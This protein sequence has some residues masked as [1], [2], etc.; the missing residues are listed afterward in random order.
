MA[1]QDVFIDKKNGIIHCWDDIKGHETFPISIVKYAYRRSP[2]GKY[3]SLYGDK[4]DRVTS[5]NEADPELFESDVPLETKFLL[6]RYP[7]DDEISKNANIVVIDIEVDST[8]GFP[9]VTK[10]DK[11][12]TAIALY[13]QTG[14]KYYSYVLDP[15]GKITSNNTPELETRSFSNE[16]SLLDVFLTT[17]EEIRPSIVTGWSSNRFDLPYLFNRI[18]AVLG[19]QTAYRLSPVGIVYQNKFNSRMVIAGIS[20]LD[21]QELYKKFVGEM[22]P[23]WSLANVAKDEELKIQKLTYKGSLTNLYKT[24][25]HRYAE[26]NLVDVKVVVELDKK[27]DFIYLARSVCHKGF[28]K[29]EWFQMSSRWI[30]GAMLSYLHSKGIVAPNK[31]LGGREMYEEMEK[32][33][34][35][36]FAGAFVKEPIPGLYDWVCSADIS[37]LYP[38]TITSLNIS[39]ETRIGEIEGWDAIAFGKG[40]IPVVRIGDQSYSAADFKKMIANYTFGIGSNGAIYRQDVRGVIPTILNEWIKE[41]KEYRALAIKYGKEGNKEKEQFYDRRQKR[42]KIFS[43]SVYGCIG[44][45]VWRFYNKANAEAVTLSGQ[46]IIRSAEKLVNDM[47]LTKF[48]DVK[49]VPPTQ[50]FV[51]Y[52]DTDSVFFSSLPIAQLSNIPEQKMVEFTVEWVQQVATRINKF[53]EYMVPRIFN[54]APEYNCIKIVPDVIARKALWV[55]KKR[56]ALLKVFDMEKKTPIKSKDGSEG[57]LEVKGIDAVRS[58]FPAAF[59]KF[60]GNVLDSLLRDIPKEV[61][62]ERIMQFEETIE[63]RPVSDLAK[64]TSVK[65]VSRDGEYNY[66]PSNRQLFQFVNRTPAQ[67]KAA[68]GYN[69]LLKVWKLNRQ[70]EKISHSEKIKWVYLL[71]NNFNIEALAFK[72]D[73][74]DPD[75][76]LDFIAEHIDRKKMYERE[77]KSKL[78]EIWNAVKWSYPNRGGILASKTFDFTEEF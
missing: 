55:V 59:R 70:Y 7:N 48:N 51:K 63:S 14:N 64:T 49:V 9:D 3:I 17:W 40:E 71:P 76:I 54:I 11:T 33:G 6:D 58:S 31:P 5:F 10:G 72:D 32:E 23:S 37:A 41:R 52:I 26:Y 35:E 34:E 73:D 47:Y 69:D 56:Y 2:T 22:K 24:D 39:P 12:I 67:V 30:D 61:L 68:L 50:D 57:K 78:S 16:D 53:Y 38:S 77:L 18:R 46:E 60:V 28:V 75:Q 27:Y 19:K 43:N 36:G 4:L 25:I 20:C 1:Y 74:T 15:E 62:D 42:Q 8:G 66:N 44:L 13:D 65:F 21:Y 29:Y 45:P